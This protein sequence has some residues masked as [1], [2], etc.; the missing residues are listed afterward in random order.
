MAASMAS[1]DFSEMSQSLTDAL[2]AGILNVSL[3]D[4]LSGQI[5]DL[6]NLLIDLVDSIDVDLSESLQSLSSES[7]SVF[8][9]LFGQLSDGFGSLI[10][11][12]SSGLS[13]LFNSF[14]SAFGSLFGGG[15]GFSNLFSGIGNLF[16]GLFAGFFER[17]GRVPER[18][19]RWSF[20][21]GGEVPIA[22]HAGEFVMQRSAVES[23]GVDTMKT[24]NR[25]G[26]LPNGAGDLAATL[27]T[28]FD[29]IDLSSLHSNLA[30][31]IGAAFD[32]ASSSL[33]IDQS[34]ALGDATKLFAG[35]SRVATVPDGAIARFRDGGG[36]G[37]RDR[38]SE[39]RGEADN[40][41]PREA[42]RHPAADFPRRPE[43]SQARSSRRGAP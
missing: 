32:E 16:G 18:P 42:R 35:M 38:R 27:S 11:N 21:E 12:L 30:K 5:D 23:V 40:S 14:S 4:D 2:D 17:G 10:G 43:T 39:S 22:A 41:E 7:S 36:Q 28:A 3:V 19:E 24:I 25:T 15:S 1:I 6:S 29:S 26:K 13:G 37:G 33:S 31:S 9:D 34:K 8:D 20:A